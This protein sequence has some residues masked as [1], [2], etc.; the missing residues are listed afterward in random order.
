MEWSSQ[1]ISGYGA[2]GVIRTEFDLQGQ[3]LRN[4]DGPSS[5]YSLFGNWGTQYTI[6]I[7]NII[8]KPLLNY[9]LLQIL[10]I[11]KYLLDLKEKR[12]TINIGV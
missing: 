2:D 9:L 7:D 11:M 1:Y 5:V 10:V 6:K 4:G 12:E 3:G 8:H